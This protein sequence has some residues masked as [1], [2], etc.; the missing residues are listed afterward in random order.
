M[1]DRILTRRQLNRALLARQ[2]LLE[3]AEVSIL[4]AVER[5]AGLQSQI[6]NPPY[7]GLWT[8]LRNFQRDDLTQLIAQQKIV[9]T[10]MMR[11]T[12]HLVTAA[13]HQRFRPTIQP[14]LSRAL[15]AFFGQRAKGLDIEK[16]VAAARPFL[17]EK[18]RTMGELGKRLSEIEPE[19]DA[20]AMNYAVRTFLPLVQ[21]HPGGTWGSGSAAY[22]TAELWF[23]PVD[24][25]DL[26]GLL[27]RYLA[28]F[29]PASVMDFQTWTG[30]TNLKADLEQFKPELHIFR[31]EQGKEL[32]DLPGMPL[33]PEDAPAPLRFIPEYDNLLIGH[34]DRARVIADEF[35]PKVFLSAG[36]VRSTFLVDGFVRG[37]WKIERAKKSAALII[38]PFADL[39]DSDRAGLIEEGERLL[40]FI[41]DKAETFEV[42]FVDA[43]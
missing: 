32:F 41:E 1:E 26:R 19:R 37:A 9:R 17:E 7:I 34:A 4:E 12:L 40:R 31:D 5:L 22:T 6:P 43:D 8:R 42:R 14:A 3:R 39:T 33:P 2:L 30:M 11:S 16:L 27:F 21:V 28:A 10:A 13:D 23:D 24:S 25:E 18:P 15:N 36:R 20:D 29:G 38:E 35:R